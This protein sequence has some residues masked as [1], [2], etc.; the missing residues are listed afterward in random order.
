MDG[1]LR[2]P[3]HTTFSVVVQGLVTLRQFDKVRYFKQDFNNTLEK[4]ANATFCYFSSNRWLGIR[5]D[6]ICAV[7]LIATTAIAFA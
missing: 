2:G 5:L 1:V 6:L 3:I 7:F 4:C